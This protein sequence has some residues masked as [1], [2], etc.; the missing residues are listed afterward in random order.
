[1]KAKEFNEF[2]KKELE[3]FP[4]KI[5]RLKEVTKDC[6]YFD[7]LKLKEKEYYI[8][9]DLLF[10]DEME[11]IYFSP[12]GDKIEIYWYSGIYDEH[13]EI[14]LDYTFFDDFETFL[15]NLKKE[16]THN[17]KIQKEKYEEFLS[18]TNTKEY[19]EY[20]RLKEIYEPNKIIN[21]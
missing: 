19:K 11:H 1:M 2:Y 18:K 4:E 14:T 15:E 12:Y 16:I 7:G 3:N 8:Y 6:I 9:D 10:Y 21:I 13:C 20:L 5:K 17:N